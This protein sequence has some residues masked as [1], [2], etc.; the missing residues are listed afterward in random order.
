VRGQNS[1]SEINKTIFNLFS[2]PLGL[3]R[4][5]DWG[6]DFFYSAWRERAPSD[7]G[8]DG[9]GCRDAC[10]VGQVLAPPA[11]VERARSRGLA[12]PCA[13]CDASAFGAVRLRPTARGKI[14]FASRSALCA[15][16]TPSNRHR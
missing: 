13:V 7:A 4:S 12:R 11:F 5:G 15:L 10:A 14:F 9:R 2:F 6:G 1:V 8:A 16:G 3:G